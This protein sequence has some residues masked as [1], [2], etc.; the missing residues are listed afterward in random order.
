VAFLGN[1]VYYHFSVK[2]F[3]MLYTYAAAGFKII[4]S[5]WTRGF[6][7]KKDIVYQEAAPHVTG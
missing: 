1:R 3:Q 7:L 4:F 5:K 6:H 2:N